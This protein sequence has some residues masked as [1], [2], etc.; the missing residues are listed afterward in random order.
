MGNMFATQP[1]GREILIY[2][3]RHLLAG[4]KLGEPIITSIL[5]NAE[6]HFIPIIDVSFEKI[7]EA[8]TITPDNCYNITADF[9][10]I[11]DQLMNLGKRGNPQVDVAK[12][13]KHLLV[14]GKFDLVL[15][16][17][18]GDISGEQSCT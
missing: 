14:S 5:K 2:L 1:L 9:I 16:I 4:A 8:I 17:E 13:L 15:N 10:Q 3:A 7:A 12:A 18:G 6:L 11:G